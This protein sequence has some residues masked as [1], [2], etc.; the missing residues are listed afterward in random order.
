MGGGEGKVALR[1]WSP[2]FSFFKHLV[3][4]ARRSESPLYRDIWTRG[5]N[6][7]HVSPKAVLCSISGSAIYTTVRRELPTSQSGTHNF[8]KTRRDFSRRPLSYNTWTTHFKTLHSR[9]ARISFGQR[10]GWGGLRVYLQVYRHRAPNKHCAATNPIQSTRFVTTSAKGK[11]HLKTWKSPSVGPL[12]PM[13]GREWCC[14][15]GPG[16]WK[17]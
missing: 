2:S 1:R 4:R 5:T 15:K 13:S 9:T 10:W 7:N 12:P 8:R 3:S 11:L 17:G 14:R 6:C 16:C